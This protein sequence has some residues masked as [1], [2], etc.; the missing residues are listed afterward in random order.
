MSMT[1]PSPSTCTQAPPK[2]SE[3]TSTL[4]RG[5]RRALA[6]FARSG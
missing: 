5:S 2:S 3:S 4:T 1:S 6:V